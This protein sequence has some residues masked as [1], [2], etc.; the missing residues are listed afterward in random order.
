[1]TQPALMEG[2]EQ[3]ELVLGLLAG[4]K[5]LALAALDQQRQAVLQADR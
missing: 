3:V 4:R 5:P 2:L 1:V